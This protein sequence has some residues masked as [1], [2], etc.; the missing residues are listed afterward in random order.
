MTLLR[1]VSI[2]HK[3]T[4]SQSFINHIL[5]IMN[6]LCLFVSLS[7]CGRFL[8]LTFRSGLKYFSFGKVQDMI[9]K[10]KIS[11]FIIILR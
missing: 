7:L 6:A 5:L 8:F 1:K 3:G 4:K 9:N 11:N 2:C 10:L